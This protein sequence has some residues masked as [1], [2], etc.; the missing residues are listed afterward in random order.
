MAMGTVFFFV[1]VVQEGTEHRH[2]FVYCMSAMCAYVSGEVCANL[3]S[4]GS[5]S[6]LHTR[7]RCCPMHQTGQSS[8]YSE[9]RP[10][11]HSHSL[12]QYH[13]LSLSAT[14]SHMPV[15]HNCGLIPSFS[16]IFFSF[17]N[18]PSSFFFF[19]LPVLPLC[20][21]ELL[22][23]YFPAFFSLLPSLL[24]PLFQSVS[25]FC[26]RL[27]PPLS[28]SFPLPVFLLQPQCSSV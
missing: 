17:L 14:L 27:F 9:C 8:C 6:C 11:C 26:P 23:M 19:L 20:R 18:P 25:L 21:C 16:I 12:R 5:F 15:S 28:L 24:A 3:W 2:S 22:I 10:P 13:L 1:V 7:T 4:R